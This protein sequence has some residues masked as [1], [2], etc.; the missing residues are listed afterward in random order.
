MNTRHVTVGT[1][2][3]V[4]GVLSS[5]PQPAAQN[6]AIEHDLAALATS[7]A[8]TVFNRTASSLTDGPRKGARL[9]ESEGDGVA[10]IAG[11]EFADGTIEFDVRGKD[12][13]QRSFVGVAFHGVD[14]TT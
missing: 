1:F 4:V 9:S 6:Q 7:R 2:I 14:A 11:I 10:Y 13:Q 8:F 5:S 12:V 3:C